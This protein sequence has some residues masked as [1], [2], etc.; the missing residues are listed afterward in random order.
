MPQDGQEIRYTDS[1]WLEIY[2]KQID[3]IIWICHISLRPQDMQDI[4]QRIPE[5][6]QQ[7][8]TSK[9]EDQKG[10]MFMKALNA[11]HRYYKLSRTLIWYGWHREN[12]LIDILQRYFTPQQRNIILTILDSEIF[13]I[14]SKAGSKEVLQNILSLVDNEALRHNI[15]TAQDGEGFRRAFDHY[16]LAKTFLE[17]QH[18]IPEHLDRLKF[19]MSQDFE[20]FVSKF[21]ECRD[22]KVIEENLNGDSDL[23]REIDQDI[24]DITSSI[25]AESVLKIEKSTRKMYVGKSIHTDALSQD[26][27]EMALI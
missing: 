5:I 24:F 16:Y 14:L 25:E 18:E 4:T 7:I 11:D 10:H 8:I 3:D 27:R 12:R 23:L 22:K 20:F 2:N 9:D 21:H 6:K 1:Q 13:Q 15:I 17:Y 19:F 26:T